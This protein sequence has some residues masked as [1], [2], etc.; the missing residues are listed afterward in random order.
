MP[1][2][3]RLIVEYG[4]K[5]L[6]PTC[7]AAA[8]IGVVML[9]IVNA[10]FNDVNA[11]DKE[12]A[13]R[14]ADASVQAVLR[15]IEN[16][17]HANGL[18]NDAVRHGYEP[19]DNEWAAETWG[20]GTSLGLYNESFI[21]NDKGKTLFAYRNGRPL[22]KSFAEALGPSAPKLFAGLPAQKDAFGTVA[23]LFRNGDDIYAVSAAPLLPTTRALKIPQVNPNYIVF[24]K[25][26]DADVL[27]S[28][29]KQ[30]VLEGLHFE[31]APDES[32]D[33]L[34]ISDIDDNVIGNLVWTGRKPGDIAR[35]KYNDII[36]AMVLTI[37]LMIGTLAY[38]SWLSFRDAN[39]RKIQALNNA[40]HD[41]L[42]G[43]ANR[44][45]LTDELAK[46]TTDRAFRPGM[47]SIICADLDGFKD[48]NDTHGHEA[49]DELLRAVAAGFSARAAG[50]GIAAR[51][52]G[53][54]F[55]IIV[56]GETA[57]ASARE[58]A[59]AMLDF[60]AE[61]LNFAGHAASIG[62]SIGLV[63]SSEDARDP[64]ELLRRADIAMYAAKSSGRHRMSVYQP[65]MDIQR[66][67]SRAIAAHLREALTNGTLGI[68]YQPIFDA[69][70]LAMTSVE[71]LVRWPKACPRAI[72]PDVFIPIA[73]EYGLIG[74][75]GEYVLEN[76]CRE[77]TNWPGI[78]VSVNVSSLQFR[79]TGF[80]A[81]V[82]RI[83]ERTGLPGNRLE[84]EVTESCVI[85][86]TERAAKMIEQLHDMQV[87]VSLDDFGTGF[88]SIG[89][90]RQLKF[91]SLKLDR[92]LVRDIL[93]SP[94]ALLLLRA[95]ITMAD[96]LD[97][98]TTAEGIENEKEVPLLR[99]AGCRSFQGYFFSKPLEAAGITALRAGPEIENVA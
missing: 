24:A 7:I 31:A 58:I 73:E 3:Q 28:L 59:A 11:L 97:I 4:L 51:L 99:L 70:T 65:E 60:L 69:H 56:F 64:E 77:A 90:L 81:Q 50:K 38:I 33:S 34:Q 63:D 27:A 18:W 29:A 88:S 82:R 78:R 67:E 79:N 74:D 95:T 39:Q 62:V 1:I 22:D 61:P 54:E 12:Y 15:R 52:G 10:I 94:R 91:D 36:R 89:H 9:N 8:G 25:L 19:I 14:A 30:H 53:D 40:L 71:A 6:I 92:S 43:L 87:Q 42:T 93:V 55:A 37:L 48:V 80:P 20:V 85:E 13:R 44:R 5:V 21:V 96:A 41:E 86:N 57:A 35:F 45:L 68:V 47:F 32:A 2:H 83:L 23:A 17:A 46:M 16:V 72:P 66:A 84:L 75:I 98:P 76:A 49:G 26:I